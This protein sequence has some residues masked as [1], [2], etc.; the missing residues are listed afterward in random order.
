MRKIASHPSIIPLP[1]RAELAPFFDISFSLILPPSLVRFRAASKRF[2]R[3][4]LPIFFPFANV[5]R[6]SVR[7]ERGCAPAPARRRAALSDSKVQ[8]MLLKSISRYRII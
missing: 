4:S 6:A 3:S 5:K 2:L 8:G 1:P 7:R